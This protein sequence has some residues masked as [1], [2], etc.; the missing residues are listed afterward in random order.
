MPT[1]PYAAALPKYARLAAS[2]VATAGAAAGAVTV[3]L[4]PTAFSPGCMI[5]QLDTTADKML[6]TRTHSVS[7]SVD[8]LV[9]VRP[10]ASFKPSV[11]EWATLLEW[12]LCGVPS[13]TSYPLGDRERDR[14]LVFDDTQRLWSMANVAVNS[15]TFASSAGGPLTLDVDCVGIDYTVAAS[16]GFPTGLTF[17]VGPPFMQTG[18]SIAIGGTTAVP[19][20][21]VRLTVNNSL[22]GE[23]FFF[24]PKI[25]GAV[26]TD[27]SV[28]VELEIPYG[29]SSAIWAAGAGA[30]GVAVTLTYTRGAQ[31]LVFAM[32]TVRAIAPPPQSRTPA[33]TF[34]S[35]QGMALSDTTNAELAVTYTP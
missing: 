24:G 18:L 3:P 4:A 5:E 9:R 16:S 2:P 25:S 20:R 34:I 22:D 26:A 7:G 1:A 35:W 14:L 15:A 8:N 30:G 33:E 6:G 28:E 19:C 13:G 10:S 23:R 11:A 31:S 21:G 12:C 32:P 27:R 29:L 17:P